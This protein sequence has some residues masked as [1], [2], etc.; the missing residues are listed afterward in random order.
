V[1]ASALAGLHLRIGRGSLV[2][3]TLQGD[4]VADVDLGISQADEASWPRTDDAFVAET[5]SR[6]PLELRSVTLQE[7]ES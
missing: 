4:A 7:A 2:Y 1:P 3:S 5:T 6:E